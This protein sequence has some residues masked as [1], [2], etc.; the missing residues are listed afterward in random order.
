M[1]YIFISTIFSDLF[2]AVFLSGLFLIFS[3]IVDRT[4]INLEIEL[5]SIRCSATKSDFMNSLIQKLIKRKRMYNGSKENI[6]SKE[7][8]AHMLEHQQ[9]KFLVYSK[10]KKF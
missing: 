8:T 10:S 4:K 2:V 9:K 1:Y 3:E 5:Q 7:N 6:F